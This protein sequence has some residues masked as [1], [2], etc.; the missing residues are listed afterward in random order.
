MDEAIEQIRI[1]GQVHARLR[2][3]DRGMSLGSRDFLENLCKELKASLARDRLVSIE[4]EAD[5]LPLS[6]DQAVSLGLAVNEL[7]T[8]ANPQ[9]AK[10]NDRALGGRL[11]VTRLPLWRS[12]AGE[13]LLFPTQGH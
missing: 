13:R 8:N 11:A 2:A 9:G 10:V 12:T 3:G 7:V 6:N 1:M 5:D 4:C